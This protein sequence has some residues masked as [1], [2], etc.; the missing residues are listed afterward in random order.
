MK[1]ALHGNQAK[2]Y[3]I[4][5]MET[6]EEFRKMKVNLIQETSYKNKLVSAMYF[7]MLM[8]KS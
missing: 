3:E 1:K 2:M 8:Q 6:I 5:R 4:R 7:L